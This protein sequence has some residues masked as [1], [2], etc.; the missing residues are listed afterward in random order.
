MSAIRSVPVALEFRDYEVRVSDETIDP[1]WDAFLA[2]T[3]G[4]Y[5]Q[6][7]MWAR[8]KSGSGYQTRRIIAEHGGTIVGGAQLLLRRLRIV[9]AFGYVPLGPVLITED[10][11]LAR[12]VVD[13]IRKLAKNEQLRFIAVQAPSNSRGATSALRDG[14]FS[15]L[16]PKLAP[17]ASARI[18]LSSD[19]SVI[20]SQMSATTRKHLRRSER[21]GVAVREGTSS[22][23]ATFH[24]LA[25]ATAHRR[26]FTAPGEDYLS[27]VWRA[28]APSG[29]IKIFV[30]EIV[31]E[32]LSA[33]SVIAFGNTVTCWRM[34][35]A[36]KQ[37][38]VYPNE[39]MHWTAMRW[40]K[41]QGYRYFDLGGINPELARFILAGE[42]APVI[43]AY[44]V[45]HFKLGFGGKA[46]LSPEPIGYVHNPMLR[47]A[48]P[49]LSTSMARFRRSRKLMLNR[50]AG[51]S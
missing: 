5:P 32:A 7:S 50:F 8:V 45:D 42:S 49:L 13:E 15:M 48:W 6:T 12:S 34:G 28:F 3:G 29:N 33:L 41:S 23:L 44:N 20:F 30:A 25:S 35:W 4:E 18:N 1:A 40:A 16:S 47:R 24:R 17:T 46:T 51:G 38:G 36:G 39:A 31:G 2:A 27:R 14:G 43:P 21:A 11:S 26:G 22:D 37:T 10:L 9:G 19:L